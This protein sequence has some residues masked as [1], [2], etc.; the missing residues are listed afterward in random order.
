MKRK[1]EPSDFLCSQ[2]A[3]S[4]HAA[5]CHS[6]VGTSAFKPTWELLPRPFFLHMHEPC[7]PVGPLPAV[8]ALGPRSLPV[9]RYSTPAAVQAFQRVRSGNDQAWEASLE[10]RLVAAIRKW[11]GIISQAPLEFDL[12]RRVSKDRPLGDTLPEGLRYV[13]AGKA[14][15]TLHGRANPFLRFIK[16]CRDEGEEPFPLR[17]SL[18][19]SFCTGM[20][21]ASSAPTFLHSFLTTLRFAHYV[22]G[23]LGALEC[24]SSSRVAGVA[25][26]MFLTKKKK[27]QR[28]ALT[29]KMVAAL[30]KLAADPDAPSLDRVIAGFFVLLVYTRG[31]FSDGLNMQN[32]R[33]EVPASASANSLAGYVEADVSRTKAAY[34]LERKTMYLP[35]VAPRHGVTDYDWFSGF[36][37]ARQASCVPSGPGIPLLPARS[38]SSGWATVPPT[39]GVAASWLRGTLQS[40]GFAA[41]DISPIGTHSCK[42][43]TLSWASKAGLSTATRRALGYHSASDDKMVLVYSRDAMSAPV[44][45]LESVI[46][47]VREG[48]FRPDE[49]RSGF[50][51][52]DE[53]LEESGTESSCNEEDDV[54]DQAHLDEA[55]DLCV[56]PWSEVDGAG[57]AGAPVARHKVSRMIHAVAD[58]A[59]DRSRCGKALNANYATLP[60]APN[61]MYPLCR[62]C[63]P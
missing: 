46:K 61:F 48:R 54:E 29:A 27:R 17:E 31:R 25:R 60:V 26:L 32:L 18:V 62:K 51:R 8:R 4:Q 59:G 45:E 49:T 19:F 3:L 47:D 39:A 56:Q 16:W 57:Q 55:I 44:R 12:G 21:K 11:Q 24:A 38:S 6:A 28:P 37:E 22:L 9:P 15:E 50:F 58:E 1:S 36:L 33:A 42:T 35:I 14:A 63:Y 34:T 5:H 20:E 41:R 2:D 52:S 53:E 13:F 10:A 43:T 30:E 40:L 7:V 23:L